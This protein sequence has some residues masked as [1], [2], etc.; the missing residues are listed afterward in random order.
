MLKVLLVDDDPNFVEFFLQEPLF[1]WEKHAIG[2][3][4]PLLDSDGKTRPEDFDALILDLLMPDVDGLSLLQML[5]DRH[6]VLPAV[7]IL[8]ARESDSNRLMA[9]EL[10]VSDFLSKDLST[11]EIQV[12]VTQG[13]QRLRTLSP[14]KR[15]GNMYFDTSQLCASIEGVKVDF[16]KTE[17]FI[18]KTLAEASGQQIAREEMI[19]RV[20]ADRKVTH[21]TLNTHIFNI[22]AKTP[23]WNRCL[24][25]D[26]SAYI[27]LIDKK[28]D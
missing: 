28:P 12:R 9:Y 11:K 20:W 8:T 15:L 14:L 25:V 1:D 24:S 27:C 26:G 7:F 3:A 6:K 17:F 4:A 16:T 19:E 22:N 10:G 5:K 18:L 21:Q 23:N 13:I 2:G